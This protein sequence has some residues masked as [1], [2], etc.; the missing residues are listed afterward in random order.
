EPEQRVAAKILHVPPT[1][2]AAGP[3]VIERQTVELWADNL[4]TS[5]SSPILAG[6]TVYLVNEQGDLCAVNANTGQILWLLKLGVEERNSCPLYADGKLYVPM[7][8][9]PATKSQT[10][11]SGTTGAFYVIKR[12]EEHTSELQSRS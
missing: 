7:L 8:D 1:N 6:D 9:D 5:A 12:S 11:E 2:S 3:V 10:G 4:S